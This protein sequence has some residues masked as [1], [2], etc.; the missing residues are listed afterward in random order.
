MTTAIL[1]FHVPDWRRAE[2]AQPASVFGKI[3]AAV[4][5]A[6]WRIV[7]KDENAPVEGAGYHLVYNRPVTHPL[8]LS[9]R[10]C[11]FDPFYRIESTNDRWDWQVARHNYTEVKGGDWFRKYWAERMFKDHPI[12]KQG[13]VF[14]PLQGRLCERRHFQSMSPIDMIKAALANDPNRQILATLHPRETYNTTDMAALATIKGNFALV[15]TPSLA[16]LADC[17]Y[18]VTQNSSMALIGMF[19]QKSPILFANI[20]FH[21]IAASVPKQGL[22]AAYRNL[23]KDRHW[24]N[25]LHWFFREQALSMRSDDIIG[26]LQARFRAHGW[27]I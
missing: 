22:E 11:Y 21:H 3:A 24:G 16:L 26:Q 20:D 19:A 7:I 23:H 12:R 6:D 17:D 8:A 5:D 27:P 10:R 9:L 2:V 1:N 13:F 15:D 25:Y 4:L 14:M 18:V